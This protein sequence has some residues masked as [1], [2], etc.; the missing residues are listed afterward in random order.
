MFD[1]EDFL[2]LF[3]NRYICAATALL[4][5]VFCIWV[6]TTKWR[7]WIKT[8]VIVVS[9]AF[10]FFVLKELYVEYYLIALGEEVDLKAERAFNTIKPILS[11]RR[12]IHLLSIGRKD[13]N[14]QFY[15]ALMAAERNLQVPNAKEIRSPAFFGT[16]SYTSFAHHLQF[17]M[18]YQEFLQKYQETVKTNPQPI[19]GS[20]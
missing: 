5:V 13:P 8:S 4:L 2:I 9:L 1:L 12:L 18:S 20:G 17:P 19:R 14:E 11:D 3:V 15:I 16:N 6:I 10:I 7:F